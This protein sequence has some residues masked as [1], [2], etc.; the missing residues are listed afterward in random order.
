MCTY[1]SALYEYCCKI[2][3]FAFTVAI[4]Q[5]CTERN[6]VDETGFDRTIIQDSIIGTWRVVGDTDSGTNQFAMDFRKSGTIIIFEWLNEGD[7]IRPLVQNS[8]G[9]VSGEILYT[10]DKRAYYLHKVKYSIKDNTIIVLVRN[11]KPVSVAYSIDDKLLTLQIA[12]EKIRL[13]RLP[14]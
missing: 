8:D 9:T 4:L 14:D 11:G 1:R 13:K 6:S 3:L 12:G 7:G 2:G 5:N 10:K